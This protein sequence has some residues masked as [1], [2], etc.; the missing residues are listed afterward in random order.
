MP[1]KKKS[2]RENAVERRRKRRKESGSGGGLT[3]LT[4]PEGIG[5]FSLKE[6]GEGTIKIHVMPFAAGEGNPCADPGDETYERTYWV[7]RIG[8]GKATRQ[9]VC[10]RKTAEEAGLKPARCPVCE[11]LDELAMDPEVTDD[12]KKALYPKQ[13]QL[14]I[15]VDEAERKK[16]LQVLDIS[17]HLFGKALDKKLDHADDDDGYE[18]FYLPKDDGGLMLRIGVEESKWKSFTYYEIGDIEFKERKKALPDDLFEEVPCLDDFVKVLPY[19]ELKKIYEAPPEEDDEN[20]DDTPQKP[21]KKK[22]KSADPEPKTKKEKAK[23]EEDDNFEDEAFDDD[24]P[25]KRKKKKKKK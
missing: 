9:Y 16:G 17:Y 3:A 23:D 14:F 2:K 13:R 20:D 18:N 25:P 10:P 6:K 22:K 4:L 15:V 12:A 5:F 21:K 7:H 1:K 24:E 8:H 19:K 11:H